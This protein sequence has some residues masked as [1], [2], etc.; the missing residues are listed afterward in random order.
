MAGRTCGYARVKKRGQSLEGQ[1]GA[2]TAF[3][4]DEVFADKMRGKELRATGAAEVN[5]DAKSERMPQRNHMEPSGAYATP[6]P[7]GGPGPILSSS[8]GTRRG[9]MRRLPRILRRQ[10]SRRQAR[11]WCPALG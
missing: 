7:K 6:M 5:G 3:R 1:L 8:T 4:A 11:G 9:G 10:G 2:F